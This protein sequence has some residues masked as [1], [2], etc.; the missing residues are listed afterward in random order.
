MINKLV[1]RRPILSHMEEGMISLLTLLQTSN[2]GQPRWSKPQ[3]DG[4]KDRKLSN[5]SKGI[6]PKAHRWSATFTSS[7]SI[8][9]ETYVLPS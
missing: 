4:A 3:L 8:T 2:Q 9:W 6:D 7:T 5:G 1:R